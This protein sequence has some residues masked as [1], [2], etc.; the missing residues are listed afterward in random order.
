LTTR[1]FG[2]LEGCLELRATLAT[3]GFSK[4]E[5]GALEP[6]GPKSRA[7]HHRKKKMDY[8]TGKIYKEVKLYSYIEKNTLRR[9]FKI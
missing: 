8:S 5:G 9:N 1:P 2:Q 6:W 4:I 7:S 3:P